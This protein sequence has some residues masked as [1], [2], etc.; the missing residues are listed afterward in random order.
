MRTARAGRCPSCQAPTITVPESGTRDGELVLDEQPV[1]GGTVTVFRV[2]PVIVARQLTTPARVQPAH[3]QH[4]CTGTEL[5]DQ[6]D[7]DDP[8][9]EQARW[10]AR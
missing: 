10:R 4:T 3:Q 9:I 2:G 8:G 6:P 7:R 1:D 5:D